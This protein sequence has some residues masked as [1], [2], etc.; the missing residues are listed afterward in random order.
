E[1][2]PGTVVVVVVAAVVLVDDVGSESS[3]PPT[4]VSAGAAGSCN[5]IVFAALGWVPGRVDGDVDEH[6]APATTTPQNSAANVRLRR[7]VE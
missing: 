4:S 2:T 3:V 7:R 5:E 6:A 1:Y